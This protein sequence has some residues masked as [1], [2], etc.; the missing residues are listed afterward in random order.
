[1]DTHSWVRLTFVFLLA[2]SLSNFNIKVML[3]SQ[4]KLRSI[5]CFS[6]LWRY[7]FNISVI[8]VLKCL[9]EF[10]RKDIE[11]CSF[12][13]EYVCNYAFNLTDVGSSGFPILICFGKWRLVW[14]I[15]RC[16]FVLLILFIHVSYFF[17]SWISPN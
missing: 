16:S 5:L 17:L 8:F 9:E 14:K 4:N 11:D 12:L 13:C 15:I 2:S 3:A 1:M 7:L 10:T 6:A